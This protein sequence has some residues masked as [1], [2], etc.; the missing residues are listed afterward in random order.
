M[1][2]ALRRSSRL[3]LRLAPCCAVRAACA[4]SGW[5]A[6]A[7]ATSCTCATRSSSASRARSSSISPNS[8]AVRF[9]T[10]STPTHHLL[11]PRV[12]CATATPEAV[13]EV[14]LEV[15]VWRAALHSRYNAMQ[16]HVRYSVSTRALFARR[17]GPAARDARQPLRA[18]LLAQAEHPVV[19]GARR[20]GR[21]RDEPPG[22]R[23]AR[24]PLHTGRHPLRVVSTLCR[25]QR[26]IAPLLSP[27][28]SAR[29]N[30]AQ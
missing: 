18:R 23:R 2:D 9:S 20:P 8:P 29:E 7:R 25:L 16:S 17:G 5:C 3:R 14:L 24:D 11:P 1:S 30:D 19:S 10:I 4:G 27:I 26:S 28:T 15:M 13:E 22:E 6:C 12:A 21:R